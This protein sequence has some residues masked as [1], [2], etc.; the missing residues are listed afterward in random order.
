MLFSP[1]VGREVPV[2]LVSK[3]SGIHHC[4]M[5]VPFGPG[6]FESVLQVRHPGRMMRG[7]ATHRT[8]VNWV[9]GSEKPS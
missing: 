7:P 5:S 6:A 9:G 8:P 4:L 1:D 3:L 2:V